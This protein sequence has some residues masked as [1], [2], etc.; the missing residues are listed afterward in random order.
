MEEAKAA[1]IGG[2]RDAVNVEASSAYLDAA[3]DEAERLGLAD[4]IVNVQ[5]DF[6]DVAEQLAD[7][8]LVTLDRVICCYDDMERPVSCSVE[9]A[10]RLYGVSSRATR[11][12]CGQASRSGT[13]RGTGCGG[14][15]C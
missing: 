5:G 7:A 2:V 14:T 11:A 13:T 10:S 9:R 8:D 15:R 1:G 6:V 4:R 3:R 12:G